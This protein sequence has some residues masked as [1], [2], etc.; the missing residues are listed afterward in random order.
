MAFICRLCFT[1][2][3]II[4]ART[5][6]VKITILIPKLLKKMLYSSTRL[7]IM[8]PIMTR[9]QT[10][11]TTSTGYTIYLLRLATYCGPSRSV[12]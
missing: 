7:F 8:G 4:M 10:S 11:L 3:G 5:I 9:F 6:T 1:V 12:S 2:R